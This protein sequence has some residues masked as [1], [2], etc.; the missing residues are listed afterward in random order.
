MT[1]DQVTPQQ[2]SGA[3]IFFGEHASWGFGMA[4]DIRR[5]ESW[6]T[7]GRF[8]WDGGFDTSAYSDPSHDSIGIL[9]TQRLMDSPEPSAI[10][11]DFW[12]HAHEALES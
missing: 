10:A 9:M 12:S 3:E 6:Q 11:R 4:V 1:R 7:P 5:C 8:G 2:R